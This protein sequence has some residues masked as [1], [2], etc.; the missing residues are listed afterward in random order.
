MWDNLEAAKL[1]LE[2]G[3]SPQE[4]VWGGPYDGKTAHAIARA[5]RRKDLIR[6]FE[7]L[8]II[9]EERAKSA[10]IVFGKEVV[11]RIFNDW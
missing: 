5:E 1:L 7:P 2:Y 6:L 8:P 10:E 11:K 4:V 9:T 3:A